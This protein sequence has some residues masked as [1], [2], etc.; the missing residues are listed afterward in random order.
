M[1]YANQYRGVLLVLML[2][3]PATGLFA[4][5]GWEDGELRLKYPRAPESLGA[6]PTVSGVLLLEVL[7]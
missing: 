6:D 1:R 5:Q 7:G 4:G 3:L 2:G